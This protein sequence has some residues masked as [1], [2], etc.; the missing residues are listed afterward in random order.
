MQTEYLVG[1]TI[2]IALLIEFYAL[3]NKRAGDTISEVTWRVVANQPWIAFLAGVLCG[4]FFAL[5]AE[6]WKLYR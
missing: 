6:C 3:V 1:A 4:H 5:P 2:I